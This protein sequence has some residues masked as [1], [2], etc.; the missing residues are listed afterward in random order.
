MDHL[1]AVTLKVLPPI[2]LVH[3]AKSQRCDQFS[4]PGG[5]DHRYVLWQ[6]A[7]RRLDKMIEVRM[8]HHH[9]IE[10]WQLMDRDTRL[11]QA[12]RHDDP[13]C[14]VGVGQNVEALPL[15]QD[16]GMPDERRCQVIWADLGVAVI[17]HGRACAIERRA[18]QMHG[19]T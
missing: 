10:W 18:H 13:W 2:E 8:G 6:L 15:Q 7:Q 16:C 19:K 11:D 14:E 17:R 1:E 9:E 3:P 12:F 5:N 4:Q